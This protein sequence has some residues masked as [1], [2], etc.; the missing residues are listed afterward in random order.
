LL[1]CVGNVFSIISEIKALISHSEYEF[2]KH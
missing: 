2:V 1:T